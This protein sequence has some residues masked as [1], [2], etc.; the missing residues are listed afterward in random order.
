MS[1]INQ[2]NIVDSDLYEK[3]KNRD[4]LIEL[5][6]AEKERNILMPCYCL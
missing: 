3:V 6:L 4:Q 2:L 5:H 1:L